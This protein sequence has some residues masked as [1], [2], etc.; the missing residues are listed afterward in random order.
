M[1][2]APHEYG[3]FFFLLIRQP[4]R[5]T[6][7]SSSAASDVYKRQVKGY[8]NNEIRPKAYTKRAEAAQV[9]YNIINK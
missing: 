3:V 4:T 9:V 2:K 7:S 8:E 5:F 6:L 1:Y